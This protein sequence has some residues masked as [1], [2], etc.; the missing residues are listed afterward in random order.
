MPVEALSP[1]SPGYT[2][3]R[4]RSSS[5]AGV[6]TLITRFVVEEEL[7]KGR[8]FSAK[9]QRGQ[10]IYRINPGKGTRI[11][12]SQDD[13]VPLLFLR[14]KYFS[15]ANVYR[16]CVFDPTK[17]DL[18]PSLVIYTLEFESLSKLNI[19]RGLR[20]DNEPEYEVSGDI[21]GNSWSMEVNNYRRKVVA[22]C[23]AELFKYGGPSRY[24][25]ETLY[26][27]DEAIVFSTCIFIE[28]L[29]EVYP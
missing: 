16:I 7:S 24:H 13:G 17:D 18:D 3:T 21:L 6:E 26:A 29:K 5:A 1:R 4:G 2:P 28:L 27:M 11:E 9:N 10:C 8:L 20:K 22:R 15:S 14:K 19:Y 23:R 25:V 12:V